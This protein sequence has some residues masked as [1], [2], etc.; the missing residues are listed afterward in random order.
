MEEGAAR[1]RGAAKPARA[2][3]LERDAAAV[4]KGKA[5]QCLQGGARTL[6]AAPLRGNTGRLHIPCNKTNLLFNA[7]FKIFCEIG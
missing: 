6:S 1:G 4:N 3:A 7:S 2:L 5:R